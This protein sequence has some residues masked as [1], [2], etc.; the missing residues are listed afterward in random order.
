M[1][2]YDKWQEIWATIKKN[3]LRTALTMFGVF[4]GILMLLVLLGSGRGLENGARQGFGGWATN[5]GGTGRSRT[6]MP[7]Q[8]LKPGRWQPLT[9]QDV[10]AIKQS[11]STV[12][13]LAPRNSLGGWRGGNSVFYK[14]KAGAFTVNGDYPDL[15]KIEQ[16]KL[17]SGRILNPLDIAE[18][19]KVA[20]IGRKVVSVLF[21][22][23]EPLGKYITIRGVQFLVIGTFESLD[24]D[25]GDAQ[26][27]NES[28][29]VPFSTFGQSFNQGNRV[30]WLMLTSTPGVPVAQAIND[31]Q[32]VIRQRHRIHPDD[33]QAM[34][35]FN[36]E[37]ELKEING[38]FFGIA[39]FSWF[40]GVGTLLAGVI[41]VSNIMLII[42]RERTREI[43]IRKALGATPGSIIG[44][45]LQESVVI[46]A[47]AGYIGL[48]L[49]I[50]LLEGVNWLMVS[51]GLEGEMFKNPTVDVQV[52]L[53]ALAVIVLGGLVAGW[54]PARKAASISPVE[55]IR[56]E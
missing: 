48:S 13:Y 28:V 27:E 49:G 56:T 54:I 4:W 19:R 26:E 40:V 30:G 17:L 31:V 12:Q 11:V 36:I 35:D 16:K 43:G 25:S 18:K 20:V 38:L 44:L 34:W 24:S 3:R 51:Q 37:E 21:G 5:A 10:E 29:F 33:T 6:T 46:T 39:A 8:G 2:D 23:E 47:I 41:G 50:G 22:Q 1:F 32:A 53:G 52:A 55:A 7:Y 14:T 42:V 45:I 9:V 15:F